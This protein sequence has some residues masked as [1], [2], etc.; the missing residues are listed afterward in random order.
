MYDAVAS[1]H[2]YID[3]LKRLAAGNGEL[4][5]TEERTRL[6]KYQADLAEIDL[7]KSAGDLISSEKAMDVWSKIGMAM[8]QRLLGLPTRLAPLVATSQSI[9]EI[10]E[11]LEIAIHE[12]LNEFA[13][14]DFTRLA[15]TQNGAEGIE[16]IQTASPVHNKRVG[17]R[18]KKVK[19]RKQRRAGKV[20]HSKSGVS[21]G[22]DG[23]IQRPE[24]RDGDTHDEQPDRKDGNSE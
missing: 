21:A 9:P 7:K 11:R 4:S 16:A 2:G 15:G 10:K 6:T 3:Y 5:L 13:N 1:V 8:R 12:V 14:P 23:R 20:A 19:P 17:G 22:D 24:R 18:K